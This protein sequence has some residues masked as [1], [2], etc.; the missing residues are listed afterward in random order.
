MPSIGLVAKIFYTHTNKNLHFQPLWPRHVCVPV[1]SIF[2]SLLALQKAI[3]RGLVKEELSKIAISFTDKAIKIFVK[4][5]VDH[6]TY[7]LSAYKNHLLFAHF[8]LFHQ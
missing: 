4:I 3:H 1:L 8:T 5:Q 2:P 6:M 7:L